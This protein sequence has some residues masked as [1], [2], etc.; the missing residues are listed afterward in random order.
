MKSED[1]QPPTRPQHTGALPAWQGEKGEP[2]AGCPLS[3]CS[4]TKP[5][6]SVTAFVPLATGEGD[7]AMPYLLPLSSLKCEPA[8]TKA[9]RAQGAGGAMSGRLAA[10]L[11]Q[12]RRKRG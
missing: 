5:C 9:R 4:C 11:A 3:G 10:W 6:P 2:R 12:L 7:K 1:T 8:P